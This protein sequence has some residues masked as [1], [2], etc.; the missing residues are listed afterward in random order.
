MIYKNSIL[1]GLII[2][3]I[4][5]F[6]PGC[7][8]KEETGVAPGSTLKAD[9][10][11]REA[12]A[13]LEAAGISLSFDEPGELLYP[14][15]LLPDP[16]NLGNTEKRKNLEEAIEKLNIVLAELE[17][18][19]PEGTLGSISDRALVHFYLGFAYFFDAISRL[20]ISD[21][22]SETFIIKFDPVKPCNRFYTFDISPIVRA[23]LYAAKDPLE[24]PL[25]FTVKERQAIM[26]TADLIDDAIVKPEA[27]NIQPQF[28]SVDKPPYSKYAIWHFQRAANLFGQ[29]KPDLR[30]ALEDFNAC[31]ENWR[32]GLQNNLEKWSFTYTVP[33][34]R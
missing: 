28:S 9:D 31:L 16:S 29:Y 25:A 14:E 11:L 20:L 23:K 32:A 3:S 30:D 17:R 27:L 13:N 19:V 33:P 15:N 2:S 26:D 7:S 12:E 21:D 10:T 6:F 8:E 18:E 22:P 4:L 5:L 1:L 24:Y 34:W